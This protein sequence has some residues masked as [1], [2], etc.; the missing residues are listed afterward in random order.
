MLD[1]E[2]TVDYIDRG[3]SFL[4]LADVSPPT[5]GPTDR[6]VL[7]FNSSCC[8]YPVDWTTDLNELLNDLQPEYIPLEYIFAANYIDRFG[9]EHTLRGAE[10]AQFIKHPDRYQ[11]RH[12]YLIL[13][14][15]KIRRVMH[16][17]IIEFFIDLNEHI[18]HQ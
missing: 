10:L 7:F 9:I 11:P 16:D 4:R 5:T 6:W 2:A 13:D 17:K 8:K 3:G 15:N 18:A 1:E 12:A 14:A